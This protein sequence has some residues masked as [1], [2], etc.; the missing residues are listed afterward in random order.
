MSAET[1]TGKGQ[2]ECIGMDSYSNLMRRIDHLDYFV[3]KMERLGQNIQAD[4]AQDDIR[5]L[6]RVV[7]NLYS[8]P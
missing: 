2:D 6:R 7:N 8:E 4:N 1:A 5:E 3:Q